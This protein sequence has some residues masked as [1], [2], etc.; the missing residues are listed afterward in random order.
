MFGKRFDLFRVFGF[1]IRIDTSWFLIAILIAWSLAEGLFPS[2]YGGLDPAT[3]WSMGI[4]GALGLFASVVLH[5][6]SHALVARRSGLSMKGITLFI[7]GGVAEMEQEPTSPKVEFSMAIAGPIASVVI[8]LACYGLYRAGRGGLPVPITGVIEY[9]ALI[10]GALAAFNL[11][12]AFPLDGGR[13]LRS[14]LWRWKG[15]LRWATR[16]TTQM[17]SGFGIALILLGI[18]GVLSG[19]FVGGMW[20]FLIGMF[21]RGAAQMSYQQLLLRQALEGEPVSRF[22]KAN[23]ITAPGNISIQ[24]FVDDYVY[25]HHFKMF[26][27]VND[28]NLVGAISTSQIK[29]L[30]RDEWSRRTVGAIAEEC[31]AKNTISPD[32]DTMKAIAR[33]NRAGDSRL[34]VVEGGRL[35]GIVALRDLLKFLS[36]KVEL[37]E[38][39]A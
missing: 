3:Y 32:T 21:L 20:W 38:E 39:A 1:A 5:E 12:P 27:V 4:A 14:A 33:M 31:S 35:L 11:V 7:F 10:N 13:V 22:M 28:G 36:L 15:N 8:A 25:E 16:I 34:M 24:E 19:N 37:E 29:S 30:P 18:L 17:G 9:L 26:P 23:P 6:L 2:W